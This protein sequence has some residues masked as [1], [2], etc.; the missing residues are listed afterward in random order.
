MTLPNYLRLATPSAGGRLCPL[1]SIY[2]FE[3]VITGVGSLAAAKQVMA[4]LRSK[5]AAIPSVGCIH[6]NLMAPFG[7]GT[8]ADLGVD[9]VSQYGWMKTVSGTAFPQEDYLKVQAQAVAL[10]DTFTNAFGVP[11]IPSVSVAWDPS[12]RCVVTDAFDNIGYPWGSTWRSTP[13]QWQSSLEM[14]KSYLQ[15][16]CND[17]SPTAYCPPLLI[18]AWNEWSEGAFLEPDVAQ[19]TARLDAVRAVFGH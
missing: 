9:S 11:Y 18:N 5:A 15:K 1:L 16:R 6:V 12:P 19:G 10:W 7:G 2:Q 14:A 13:A 3:Y 4:Q 17:T 8:A